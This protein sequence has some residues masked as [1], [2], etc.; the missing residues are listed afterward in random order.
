MMRDQATLAPMP[1]GAA[2]RPAWPTLFR[3]WLDRAQRW[4]V[5]SPLRGSTA[6]QPSAALFS[7]LPSALTYAK[8]NCGGKAATIELD[9][10]GLYA[11]VQQ[12]DGWTK[13][14]CGQA[15]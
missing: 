7:D 4:H 3:L 2:E 8:N 13:P 5:E 12:D 14:I 6:L 11:V 9:F 1:S 10:D 15:A